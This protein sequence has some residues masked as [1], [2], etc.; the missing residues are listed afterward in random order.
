MTDSF[1]EVFRPIRDRALFANIASAGRAQKSEVGAQSS[2]V[3][4]ASPYRF[5]APPTSFWFLA[6]KQPSAKS[7]RIDLGGRKRDPVF[8]SA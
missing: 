1:G 8:R 2:V 5:V 4:K 6:S 7:C 3:S